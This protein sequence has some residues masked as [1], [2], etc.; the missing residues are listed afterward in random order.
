MNTDPPG[1]EFS[2][3][4][5]RPS[6]QDLKFNAER[7]RNANKSAPANRASR[8]RIY[9]NL[10]RAR[11][12]AFIYADQTCTNPQDPPDRTVLASTEL[13]LASPPTSEPIYASA[14][15]RAGSHK[16]AVQA[17]R[18]GS[19]RLARPPLDLSAT[20]HQRDELAGAELLFFDLAW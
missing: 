3:Q 19:L 2:R 14:L 15:C 5:R 8:L 18:Q 10:R 7:Y 16:L 20:L 13:F 17:G 4:T 11:L 9:A 12:F 6:E 1:I